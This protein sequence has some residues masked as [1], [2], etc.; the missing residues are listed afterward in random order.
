MPLGQPTHVS[1]ARLGRTPGRRNLIARSDLA[2]RR[3]GQI[4]PGQEVVLHIHDKQRRSVAVW[5]DVILDYRTGPL[6][7][8]LRR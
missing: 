1:E 6:R 8:T 7:T 3:W 5:H 2:C 4:D